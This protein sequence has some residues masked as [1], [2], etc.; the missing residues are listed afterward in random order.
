MD[1]MN[2]VGTEVGESGKLT[3]DTSSYGVKIGSPITVNMEAY[4]DKDDFLKVCNTAVCPTGKC[5]FS[6]SNTDAF[7]CVEPKKGVLT[8][9]QE[10][11]KETSPDTQSKTV[12][13]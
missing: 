13:H 2:L 10:I 3:T 8:Q 7:G 11:G 6:I 1:L 4:T 12:K 5:G 9:T